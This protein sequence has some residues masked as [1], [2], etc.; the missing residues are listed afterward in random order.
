MKVTFKT[1]MIVIG[2]LVVGIISFNVGVHIAERSLMQVY[3]N[4]PG[5]EKKCEKAEKL[6]KEYK[7]AEVQKRDAY[8][9]VISMG[10]IMVEEC[11]R[12]CEN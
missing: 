9:A 7:D 1:A 8:R 5:V 4:L 11:R 2:F 6:A 3:G 10:A 12:K